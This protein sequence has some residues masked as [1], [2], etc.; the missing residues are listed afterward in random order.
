M[1]DYFSCLL[2]SE[3]VVHRPVQMIR[4]LS[5]L[6]VGNQ[7]AHDN[8][9]SITRS[10]IRAEPQI[11]EQYVRGVLHDS[12]SDLAELLL[13][14]SRAFLLSIL[15]QREEGGRSRRKLIDSDRAGRE[16][17]L[18]SLHCRHSVAPFGVESQM[19]LR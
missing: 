10:K 9:T 3:A 19:R 1:R 18:H 11:P 15:I 2:L 6:A 7:A 13:N 16:Y 12:R 14:T 5:G 4:N 8:E 17:R